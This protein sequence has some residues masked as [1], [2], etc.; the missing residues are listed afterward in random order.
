MK[1]KIYKKISGHFYDH[2]G[3]AVYGDFHIYEDGK[4]WSGK[5]KHGYQMYYPRLFFWAERFGSDHWIEVPKNSEMRIREKIKLE[6]LISR[7]VDYLEENPMSGSYNANLRKLL[8]VKKK[9]FSNA[10]NFIEEE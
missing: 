5:N 4:K 1:R 6:D 10:L 8:E 9:H 7:H 3:N 2:R